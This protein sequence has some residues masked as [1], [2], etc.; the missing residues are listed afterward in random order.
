[1]E[2]TGYRRIEKIKTFETTWS[3]L[4]II[5]VA[6]YAQKVSPVVNAIKPAMLVITSYTRV[7][8][9]P[10]TPT[11]TARTTRGNDFIITLKRLPDAPISTPPSTCA[12]KRG[13]I[14]APNGL[15]SEKIANDIPPT[16]IP[17]GAPNN[18]PAAKMVADINSIFGIKNKRYPRETASAV[19]IPAF[20]IHCM[21]L[22]VY[23]FSIVLKPLHLRG[24]I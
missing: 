20:A 1:L 24:K 8:I 21:C 5:P 7:I 13:G 6:R 2:R 10:P 18:H 12:I 14:E 19:K 16:V 23:V 11:I 15:N 9:P 4:K 22:F 3:I 17:T